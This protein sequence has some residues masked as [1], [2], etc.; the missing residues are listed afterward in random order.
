MS[1]IQVAD[2]TLVSSINPFLPAT[3]YVPD[4]EPHVFGDRV[5]LYGSH[6]LAEA[7]PVMCSGDYVCYS[8]PLAD[9]S[10]WRYDGV[11]YRRDQDPF[12][13]AATAQG[14]MRAMM[15]SHLFAPDVVE[16]GGKYYLYYGIG[17]SESGM[18]MAVADSP[19]GP[20]EYVGRVRYPESEK[21]AGWRDGK[22]GLD[23]GDMAFFG[24][25]AVL[26][27]RGITLKEYPYDPTLLL[28]DGR[29]FLYF[30]LMNCYVVELDMSDM[31]TVVKNASGAYATQIFRGGVLGMAREAIQKR[32]TDAHFV[33]GPS[34]REI[35]GSFV[36]SYYAAGPGGFNGMYYATADRPEGPFTPRG[37]LVSLGNARFHGQEAPT[38]HVGN[39]HGGMF[40][41]GE[42]W[43]QIY[44][45][46][47][48]S[49]RSACAVPLTRTA[50]G[51]FEHAE[52]TSM[53]FS[54]TP[55][56]A[57]CRWPAYMACH[58][59]DGK[60]VSGKAAPVIVQHDYDNA[61]GALPVVSRLQAGD[62]VGYRYF[63][64]GAGARRRRPRQHRGQ[65]RRP[66]PG[67]RRAGRPARWSAGRDDRHR[68]FARHVGVVRRTDARRERRPCRLPGR[69]AA[70]QGA[71]RPR[72][73]RIRSRPL[74]PAQP[75]RVPRACPWADK[76]NDACI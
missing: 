16:S 13:R 61:E 8:A 75:S 28:H 14:G 24:G 41:V 58:L 73:P 39:T 30:G 59:T 1:S 64:F 22:D 45:R 21:P 60:G 66:R 34:I 47:T 6:D 71:R 53:G 44:H 69:A 31:R 38:D 68:R 29:L 35:D 12:A 42:Q 4:G 3:E 48:K 15:T 5:Y 32:P 2:G 11:I 19:V 65:P 67:R 70:G 50:D 17:L 18:A 37:P 56:D 7:A 27:M 9:L 10:R 52:H 33:N 20:F 74:T 23:D 76:P 25:R 62:I 43:Y 54:T 63:D 26:S 40:A 57:F 36:L 49:G 46:H 55:L 72:L 51:G